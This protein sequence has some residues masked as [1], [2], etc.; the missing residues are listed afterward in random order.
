MKLNDLRSKHSADALRASKG[1]PSFR[2]SVWAPFFENLHEGKVIYRER[3]ICLAR[4]ENLAIT[5]IG[6]GGLITPLKYLYVP[7]Y[8]RAAPDKSW[9]FGGGWAHMTQ[10]DGTL[11]CNYAGWSIWPEA[12]RV[13]AVETLLARGDEEGAL[14]LLHKPWP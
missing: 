7:S 4:I 9:G 11:G 8:I 14:E 1:D 3:F 13:R 5:D 12:E 6:V 2:R 10:G